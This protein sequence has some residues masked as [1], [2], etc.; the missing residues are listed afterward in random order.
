MPGAAA[1]PEKPTQRVQTTRLPAVV[2]DTFSVIVVLRPT[3][4]VAPACTF[5]QVT[6]LARSRR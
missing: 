4:V 3:W 6:G 5:V 2:A 1:G